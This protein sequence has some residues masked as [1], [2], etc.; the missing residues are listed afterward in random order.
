MTSAL[1]AAVLST[2]IAIAI[3]IAIPAHAVSLAAGDLVIAGRVI[4][5]PTSQGQI[6]VYDA[7]GVFKG[8]LDTRAENQFTQLASAP[9]GSLYAAIANPFLVVH[10]DQGGVATQFPA[11][12]DGGLVTTVDGRVYAVDGPTGDGSVYTGNGSLISLYTGLPGGI[13]SIDAA[14]D[15]CRVFEAGRFNTVPV[16]DL[17]HGTT[18]SSIPV[19]GLASAVS[20]IRQLASGNLLLG[21]APAVLEVTQTGTTARTHGFSAGPLSLTL[22]SQAVWAATTI[23]T[24]QRFNLANDTATATVNPPL[25]VIDAIGVIGEPRAAVSASS[26]PTLSHLF[27]SLLLIAVAV[28]GWKALR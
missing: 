6:L 7:N 4:V 27:L 14:T 22:D 12:A 21:G 20:G 25:T 16:I 2:L 15:Q 28:V 26:I 19:S 13:L 24:V 11:F 18:L 23:T 1:R 3:A 9:D 8:I 5:G 10:F 17:C